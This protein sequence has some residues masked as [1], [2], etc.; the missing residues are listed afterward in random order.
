LLII[1]MLGNL[2]SERVKSSVSPATPIKHGAELAERGYVVI[3]PD[4]IAF[5]ERNWSE[6]PGQ[7]EYYE[8]A[9]RLVRGQTLLGK[10]L[11]GV[12]V[13][14]ALPRALRIAKIYVNFGR[15]R[16]AAM[17]RKFL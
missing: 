16:K 11:H 12:L 3:V 10:V 2:I 8:L 14:P 9:S 6:I 5:E 13:R 17:I 7:A 4:A 15:Q 1:N